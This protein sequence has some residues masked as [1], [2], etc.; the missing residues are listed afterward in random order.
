MTAEIKRKHR[1]NSKEFTVEVWGSSFLII[2]GKHVNGAYCAF[3]ALNI[4][5]E[6]SS[7]DE[8]IAY[9]EKKLR[10]A[11]NG[12]NEV[13]TASVIRELARVITVSIQSLPDVLPF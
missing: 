3:P 10:L 8:D 5:T 1:C 6:L 13:E 12:R 4:A 7:F 11:F 9:N 2:C